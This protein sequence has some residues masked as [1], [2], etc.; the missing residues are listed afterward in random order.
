[1]TSNHEHKQLSAEEK[2]FVDHLATPT[3]RFTFD[4]KLAVRIAGRTRFPLLRP[5]ALVATTCVA[6]LLWL[7]MPRQ[8]L[9]APEEKAQPDTLVVVEEDAT[10]PA[11][12][13]NLLTYAYYG[14]EFYEDDDDVEDESFLPD[15][16]E[17]LATAFASPDA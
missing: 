8:G 11:G 5:G 13:E 17:E 10:S 14:P 12:E 3:Q 16:Y 6:L 7:T 15:E 2:A 1:M 9:E 4:Q